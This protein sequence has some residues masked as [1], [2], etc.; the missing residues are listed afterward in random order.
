MEWEIGSSD[1]SVSHETLSEDEEC[2]TDRIAEFTLKLSHWCI[3]SETPRDF[4]DEL[5]G[6]LR[7]INIPVPKCTKTLLETP[8]RSVQ[9]LNMGPGE[10]IY[11]GIENMLTKIDDKALREVDEIILKVCTDGVPKFKNSTVGELMPINGE[12]VNLQRIPLFPILMYVGETKPCVDI[13]FKDF[14]NEAVRLMREGVLVSTAEIRKPFT[15]LLFSAD[16]PQRAYITATRG[17][18]SKNGCHVCDVVAK[19]IN[20]RLTYPAYRGAPRTDE[21]Y[22]MRTDPDH[23]QPE[24][25]HKPS[26]LERSGFGMVSQFPVEDLHLI[27]LGVTRKFMTQIVNDDCNFSVSQEDL[28]EMERKM[29]DLYTCIP[30]AEFARKPRT[31]KYVHKWK[32]TEGRLFCLYTGIVVLKGC[33]PEE[34][35]NHFLHLSCACR[36]IS[37]T[38]AQANADT[39][40][41]LLERYVENFPAIYGEDRLSYN[42]HNLL[43]ICEYVKRYGNVNV[44]SA[45]RNENYN[46]Q[47]Q[48]FVRKPTGILQQISNRIEEVL[49][50]NNRIAESGFSMETKELKPLYPNCP[51]YSGYKFDEFILGAKPE[52]AYCQI[53][54]DIQFRVEQFTIIN[55]EKAVIGHRFELSEPFFDSP[56]DSREVG[57]FLCDQV[58]TKSEMFPLNRIENKFVHMRYEDKIVLVALLHHIK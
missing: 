28:D 53:S 51:S 36:L 30:R 55:G 21:S 23:H 50:L 38:N 1:S 37:N 41:V 11:F 48:S 58:S 12:I 33:V 44:F 57:I 52:D 24:F 4:M 14:C 56:M 16:A 46:H 43:H 27:H 40:D 17:H 2:F 6:L 19:K 20:G 5:L 45:Y 10:Y 26:V 8:V 34:V 13:Y 32:G 18:T 3:R 42:P 54:P 7:E 39:A 29:K 31:L 47:I 25:L 49:K 35:Y 22:S 9:P 15:V